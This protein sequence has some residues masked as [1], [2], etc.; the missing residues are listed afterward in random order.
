V[1]NVYIDDA[2]K[3]VCWDRQL[4]LDKKCDV[5]VRKKIDIS[6]NR[7]MLTFIGPSLGRSNMPD[8]IIVVYVVIILLYL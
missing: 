1:C 4:K 8:V 2:G 3:I 6:S 5:S 7:L